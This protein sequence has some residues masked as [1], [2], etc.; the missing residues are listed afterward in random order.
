MAVLGPEVG[1]GLSKP[2]PPGELSEECRTH[3]LSGHNTSASAGLNKIKQ[4]KVRCEKIS[5]QIYDVTTCANK[6]LIF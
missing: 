1:A 6:L 4:I 5:Q 3:L 2:Y